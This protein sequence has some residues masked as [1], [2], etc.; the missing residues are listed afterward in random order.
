MVYIVKYLK[1][2][3]TTRLRLCWFIGDPPD[4]D[5]AAIVAPVALGTFVAGHSR[6]GSF[7]HD[8]V[9]GSS[10]LTGGCHLSADLDCLGRIRA[11]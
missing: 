11:S 9:L 7:D 4:S 6:I 5:P 2:I 1:Q 3:Q 10:R 8:R